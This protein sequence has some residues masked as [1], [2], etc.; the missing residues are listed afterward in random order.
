MHFNIN[1]IFDIGFFLLL[2]LRLYVLVWGQW[3]LFLLLLFVCVN[4]YI[5]MERVFVLIFF[6]TFEVLNRT[7][8]QS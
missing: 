7:A 5:S 2:Y 1:S 3:L 8:T 4:T 6:F